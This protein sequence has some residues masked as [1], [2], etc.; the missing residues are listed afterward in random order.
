MERTPVSLDSASPASADRSSRRLTPGEADEEPS[1]ILLNQRN[2]E[3]E[4]E[5]II[6]LDLGADGLVEHSRITSTARGFSR[7]GP[8]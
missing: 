7:Q 1:I 2:G 8:V 5:G 4:I 6:G 3:W